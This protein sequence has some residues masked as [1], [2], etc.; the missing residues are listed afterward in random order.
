MLNILKLFYCH[1]HLFPILIPQSILI[2]YQFPG[3]LP[4]EQ[5]A[6]GPFY[7]VHRG[8]PVPQTGRDRRT[9]R[10]GK[11]IWINFFAPARIRTFYYIH[12]NNLHLQQQQLQKCVRTDGWQTTAPTVPNRSAHIFLNFSPTLGVQILTYLR[13]SCAHQQTASDCL[14]FRWWHPVAI[15]GSSSSYWEE[16][17]PAQEA[18]SQFD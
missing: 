2:I 5:L 13:G 7:P 4:Q 11:S 8:D 18:G 16:N 14:Q 15:P 9:A 6:P 3:R 1:N 17:S 12:S 10:S